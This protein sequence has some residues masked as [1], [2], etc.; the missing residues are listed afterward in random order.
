MRPNTKF[1]GVT[2]SEIFGNDT[3][4][5]KHT[6]ASRTLVVHGEVKL[7]LMYL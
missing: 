5:I 4:H 7:W 6:I 2:S 1:G 3:P